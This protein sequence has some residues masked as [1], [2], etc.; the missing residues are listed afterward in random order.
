MWIEESY[1]LS[2]D[3]ILFFAASNSSFVAARSIV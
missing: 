1:A 2:F 3:G